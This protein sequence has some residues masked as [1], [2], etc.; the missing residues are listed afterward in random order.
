MH[1]TH[2]LLFA[3]LAFTFLA[4][5]VL[6][7]DVIEYAK[8][9][10][11]ARLGNTDIKESSGLAVS[12]TN[13]NLF[14]T[15]NRA[16]DQPRFFGF[17]LEGTHAIEYGIDGKHVDWADMALFKTDRQAFM[18]FADTGDEELKRKSYTLYVLRE[19]KHSKAAK[20]GKIDTLKPQ[21]VIEFT[22]EGG[23][24]SCSAMGVDASDVKGPKVIL[25]SKTDT[26]SCKVFELSLPGSRDK[27]PFVAKAI[28][29]LTIPTVTSLTISSDGRRA[30]VLTY[31]DA[32]EYTRGA[33]QTWAQAFSNRARIL[34]MPTRRKGET[35]CYG[36]DGKTLYLTAEGSPAPFWVVPVR[37]E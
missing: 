17:N 7:E 34:E 37:A 4:S 10:Q 22:Y 13:D 27:G 3:V 23:P 9:R 29:T 31:G 19:P 1:R 12:L 25:I 8:P 30:M 33:D 36:T 26:G 20:F 16:G 32:Y 35:I 2:S 6:A 5:V 15:H 18:V 21:A 14:W 28:A 11:I 24:Q